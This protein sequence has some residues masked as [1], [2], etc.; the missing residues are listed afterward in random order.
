[1]AGPVAVVKTA[2]QVALWWII[3]A[4]V[5]LILLDQVPKLGGALLIVLVLYLAST[6]VRKGVA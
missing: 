2:P 5:L 4:A 3:G 6:A 1:M